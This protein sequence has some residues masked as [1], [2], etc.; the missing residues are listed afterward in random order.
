MNVS[1]FTIKLY[2]FAISRMLINYK[3][4]WF[5]YAWLSSIV[6][7]SEG[8]SFFEGCLKD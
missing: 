5:R 4:K 1:Y 2:G 7:C 3:W 8:S 6:S